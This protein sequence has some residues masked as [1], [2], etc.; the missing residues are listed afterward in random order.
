MELTTC[1][2]IS[3]N[4]K[5]SSKQ[6]KIINYKNERNLMLYPFCSTSRN[7]RT[8]PINYQSEDGTR[9]LQVSANNTYGMAKI[10]DF[11]ILRFAISKIAATVASEENFPS[12]VSFTSYECLKAL[13]KN[14]TGGSN[15]KWLR[16]ALNRLTSTTY[17]GNIF[18]EESKHVTGFTLIK[19]DYETTN[20]SNAK[21]VLTLDERIIDSIRLSGNLLRISGD[22]FS[23]AAGIKKRLLELVGAKLDYEDE[24]SIK[25]SQLQKLCANS[26]EER[27]FKHELKMFNNLPWKIDMRQEGTETIVRFHGKQ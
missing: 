11:D 20:N 5:Q 15:L 24:W 25:L 13:G 6:V 26:W 2:Q 3:N 7:K 23:E 22:L 9:W 16:E 17:I 10:W 8:A 21:I 4:S 27:R 12:K 19:Y 1:D 14:P 18:R